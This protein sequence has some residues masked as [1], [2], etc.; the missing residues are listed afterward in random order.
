[1]INARPDT[2]AGNETSAFATAKGARQAQRILD[3]AYRC[4]VRDGYAASSMQRIADEA[5]V[6]KRMLHYYFASRERL[7]EALVEQVGERL[8]EPLEERISDLSDP[9]EIVSSGL[10]IVWEELLADP[11]PQAV[12]LALVVE[13]VDNAAMRAALARVGDRFRE[14]IDRAIDDAERRGWSLAVERESLPTLVMASVQ[15]LIIQYLVRGDS[16]ELQLARESFARWLISLAVP[17]AD[18]AGGPA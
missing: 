4:V 12:Y 3:A 1:M 16:A 6:Q 17:P 13:A 9:A 8:L 18:V 10:G 7:F 2:S 14:Q 5:G 15:G 11:E